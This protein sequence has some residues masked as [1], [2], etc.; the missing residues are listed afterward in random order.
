ML[1]SFHFSITQAISQFS[2]L[3]FFEF[4][5]KFNNKKRQAASPNSS[6]ADLTLILLFFALHIEQ[7]CRY[8]LMFNGNLIRC[9][10]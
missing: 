9:C 2:I 8:V 7:F 5:N 4:M 10:I 6:I 3:L 1:H